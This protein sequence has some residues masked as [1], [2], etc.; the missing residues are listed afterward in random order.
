MRESKREKEADASSSA[1]KNLMRLDLSPNRID[2]PGCMTSQSQSTQASLTVP[3]N[4]GYANS[5]LSARF[6]S[7]F[8]KNKKDWMVG[9]HNI[10]D[11]QPHIRVSLNA[12]IHGGSAVRSR[13]QQ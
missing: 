11:K 6:L 3:F 8:H 10:R 12:L 2:I 13:M 4:P 1:E 5:S 9:L 7:T